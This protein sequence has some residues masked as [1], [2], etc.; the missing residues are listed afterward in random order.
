MGVL[1]R[2]LEQ[3][4]DRLKGCCAAQ[5]FFAGP[6]PWPPAADNAGRE[7]PIPLEWLDL[8]DKDKLRSRS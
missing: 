2:F 7:V 1:H 8:A 3:T 4:I 5:N 6:A